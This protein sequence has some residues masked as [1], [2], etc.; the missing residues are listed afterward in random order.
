MISIRK[1]TLDD[2]SN[3]AALSALVWLYTYSL[4]GIRNEIS[5]YA[6]ETFTAEHIE[7]SLAQDNYHVLIQDE[8]IV[9]FVA[10]DLNATSEQAQGYEIKTLYIHPRFHRLGLGRKLLDYVKTTYGASFWLTTW[11]GNAPALEFYFRYGF[12]DV[13]TTYFQLSDEQHEN[14]VLAYHK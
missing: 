1:A 14:R 13:G 8:H 7:K 4:D 11:V 5:E 12:K 10:V 2:A 9:G 6:L 3:I